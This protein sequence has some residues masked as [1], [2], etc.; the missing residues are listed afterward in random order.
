MVV[1]LALHNPMPIKALREKEFLLVYD[2]HADAVFRYCYFRLL[3]REKAEETTQ[4]AFTR[5]W[6][7]LSSG[8]TVKN[9]RPFVYQVAKN[10]IADT[11]RK[12]SEISLDKLRESGFDASV[13]TRDDQETAI[14]AEQVAKNIF[15]LEE[16]YREVLV[17]R[18]INDF[19]VKEIV[20]L[21]GENR[22]NV[23]VRIHRGL[24]KLKEILSFPPADN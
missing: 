14:D 17:L 20:N 3:N 4:E 2:K 7:Y 5:T 6:E 21:I 18:Y 15:R 9:L 24:K 16:K 13:E 22:S 1:L 12:K 10:I 8:K 11:F 19:S 23:S